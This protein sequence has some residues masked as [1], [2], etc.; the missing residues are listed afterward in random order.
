MTPEELK[1][2]KAKSNATVISTS[3]ST[4]QKLAQHAEGIIPG[5]GDA[6]K[7]KQTWESI[8]EKN[9]IGE[10]LSPLESFMEGLSYFTPELIAGT[11]GG[12]EYG[13]DQ[14]SKLISESKSCY[15]K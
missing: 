8:N 13:P 14:A 9:N 15:A 10:P 1:K 6:V 3:G 11:L 2:E 4:R 7:D 5:S 12:W